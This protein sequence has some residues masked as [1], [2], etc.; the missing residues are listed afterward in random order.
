[1]GG[2]HKLLKNKHLF[3]NLTLPWM[4][5]WRWQCSRDLSNHVFLPCKKFQCLKFRYTKVIHKKHFWVFLKC[6]IGSIFMNM[7]LYKFLPLFLVIKSLL[8]N[9]IRDNNG[10]TWLFHWKN[11]RNGPFETDWDELKLMLKKSISQEWKHVS[12]IC[13]KYLKSYLILL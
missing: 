10:L 7:S 8:K 3:F 6:T 11:F 1:M 5:I 12:L 4:K 9:C 2:K 13:K